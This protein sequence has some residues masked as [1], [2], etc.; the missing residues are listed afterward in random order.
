MLK[1]KIT[2]D[3]NLKIICNSI[4]KLIAHLNSQLNI[5]NEK[6]IIL[7]KL[8]EEIFREITMLSSNRTELTETSLRVRNIFELY[9]ITKHVN[10]DP[11]GLNNWCGQAHKD[12]T[13][14]NNG[15]IKLLS[16]YNKNTSDFKE[17]QSFINNQLSHTSFQSKGGFNMRDLAQKYGY[18]DDY[19]AIYK[20]CSKLVHP[21]SIKVNAYNAL[22]EN[23]LKILNHVGV[24]FCQKIEALAFEIRNA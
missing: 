6:S 17:V 8:F 7:I 10:L 5:N 1:I 19:M 15:F 16:R 23:Y 13:V 11:K 3:E 20:L 14:I 4:E 9:L 22:N 2:D 12:V 18:D 21:S 24:F